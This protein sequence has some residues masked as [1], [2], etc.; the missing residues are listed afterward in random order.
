MTDL[1]KIIEH[2]L[3]KVNG[4]TLHVVTAG[5][6]E[7]EP[8]I[9]LHG[10][11]EFWYGWKNQIPALAA[12]GYRVIVP[13]QRGYNQS[14]KPKGLDHYTIEQLTGDVVALMESFGYSSVNLIGHDWG[15]MVSWGVGIY[16]PNRV[17]KLGILNV[18][19]PKVFE[20]TLRRD[21]RQMLKSWYV[22]AIQIPVL[23]ERMLSA[24]DFQG[25]SKALKDSGKPS[26]FSDADIEKYKEAWRHE[27]ALTS[28]MNWYRAYVRKPVRRPDNA[29]LPMP[30]LMI[31]G[32]NDIA[33]S[34]TMAQPSIEMC[35]DGK[36][37]MIDDA[38]H[39]VQHDAAER[40][41]QLLLEFLKS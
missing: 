30:T 40:V 22:L 3:V 5:P 33:L 10:F 13:D 14:D 17:R 31:W 23:P 39:W 32:K 25:M 1:E 19:H 36:L 6:K 20:N 26:S 21:V 37:V 24:N 28:M 9:L 7:G 15:A 38:T 18:P 2:H 27:G 8:V 16:H 12:A 41:N 35:D 29:R 34:E 11:P 4:V